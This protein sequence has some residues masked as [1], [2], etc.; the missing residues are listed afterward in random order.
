MGSLGAGALHANSDLDLI[1]IFDSGSD[2]KSEGLKS[3]P[4]R[5][6]L[7]PPYQSNL[8]PPYLPQ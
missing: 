2:D 3:I 4:S 6:L 1:I 5:Q 7:F 8:L